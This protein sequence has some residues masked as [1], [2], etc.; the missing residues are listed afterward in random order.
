[1]ARP[2]EQQV[3]FAELQE[4]IRQQQLDCHNQQIFVQLVKAGSRQKYRRNAMGDVLIV[5]C[6]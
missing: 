5:H 6:I 3:D 1:M 2:T 4:R